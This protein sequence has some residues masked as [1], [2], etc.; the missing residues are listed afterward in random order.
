MNTI[1]IDHMSDLHVDSSFHRQ[2]MKMDNYFRIT[3][4]MDSS[5]SQ[6]T[7]IQELDKKDLNYLI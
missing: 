5:I 1:K 7:V 4:W 3:E 6:S 2:S